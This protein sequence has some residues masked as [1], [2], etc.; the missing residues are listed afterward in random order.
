MKF[1]VHKEEEWPGIAEVYLTDRE[2]GTVVINIHD[3]KSI[4][5]WV[6][7]TLDPKKGIVLAGSIPESLEIPTDSD[8]FIEVRYD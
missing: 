7:G 8:G 4:I 6:I 2:D 5:P 1:K 3:N